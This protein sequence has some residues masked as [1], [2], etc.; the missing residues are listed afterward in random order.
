MK[1]DWID[2][3]IG[4]RSKMNQPCFLASGVYNSGSSKFTLYMSPGSIRF[5]HIN[6]VMFSGQGYGFDIQNPKANENYWIYLRSNRTIMV[7]GTSTT[8]IPRPPRFDAEPLG[9]V[10]SI[11][12]LSTANMRGPWNVGA[13]GGFEARGQMTATPTQRMIYYRNQGTGTLS[14]AVHTGTTTAS[15]IAWVYLAD[16]VDTLALEVLLHAQV[17][18]VI[19][20]ALQSGV[21]YVSPTIAIFDGDNPGAGVGPLWKQTIRATVDQPADSGGTVRGDHMFTTATIVAR[22]TPSSTIPNYRVVVWFTPAE[23]DANV[24]I[25]IQDIIFTALPGL[26]SKS[27]TENG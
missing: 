12:S 14:S 24:G 22:A 1:N 3:E 15:G 7:S 17:Q 9:K 4:A 18:F 13:F 25:R 19:S 16:V 6:S 26:Y 2:D 21:L 5:P 10:I 8:D 11:S 23:T 27:F 20:G